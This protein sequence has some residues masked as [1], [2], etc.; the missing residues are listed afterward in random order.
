MDNLIQLAYVVSAALFIF[1]LKELGSP[2]SARRGNMI[3]STGMLVAIVAAPE[4]VELLGTRTNGT[5]IYAAALDRPIA[6]MRIGIVREFMGEGLDAG[7]ASA[8]G[9]ATRSN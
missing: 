6:G 2:A 9:A 7:V 1:G 3:S 5:E 4:G 8:T